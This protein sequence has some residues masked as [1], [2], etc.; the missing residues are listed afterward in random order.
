MRC[1]AVIA[2][3]DSM[4]AGDV[5]KVRW[6]G[7]RCLLQRVGGRAGD[8]NHGRS[9]G[10]WIPGQSKRLRRWIERPQIRPGDDRPEVGT[11]TPE[12]VPIPD[13]VAAVKGAIG[14][15]ARGSRAEA[16]HGNLPTA[17]EY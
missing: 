15:D 17:D 7:L 5:A 12:V 14:D 10:G 9:R 11:L 8:N 3:R 6:G 1:I 16:R 2:A 13:T 4:A